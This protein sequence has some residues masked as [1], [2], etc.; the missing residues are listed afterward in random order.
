MFPFEKGIDGGWTQWSSWSACS[1]SCKPN[2]SAVGKRKRN[3]ACTNPR[4]SG[5][6]RGCGWSWYASNQEDVCNTD[7]PCGRYTFRFIESNLIEHK[8]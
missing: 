1:L 7:I 3:R 6:G 5:G 2:S 4:P 8:N